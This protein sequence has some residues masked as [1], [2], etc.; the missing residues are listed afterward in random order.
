MK[1]IACFVSSHGFGHAARVS[2][3]LEALQKREEFMPHIFTTAGEDIFTQTLSRFSYHKQL[4]DIGFI[5]NDAFALNIPATLTALDSLLPYQDDTVARSAQI[6]H[7]C[8][9]I[10]CDISP[11]GILVGQKAGIPSI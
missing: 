4:N 5:Q 6:C 10:L 7:N 9:Y 2:A 11:L 3:I 8:S 1:N